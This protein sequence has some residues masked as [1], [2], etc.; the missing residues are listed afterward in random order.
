M[1]RRKY[2]TGIRPWKGSW[3]AYLEVNGKPI[4]QSFP[5]DTPFEEMR[6]WRRTEKKKYKELGPTRGSFAADIESYLSRIVALQSH[7][8]FK[9]ILELWAAA[10]GRNRPRRSITAADIDQTMQQWELEG[11]GVTVLRKRR[12]VLMALWHR[13]DGKHAQNP[14][15]GTRAPQAPKPEARG[16]PYPTIARILAA[17]PEGPPKR[18]AAVIAYTGLPPSIL[19][20]VTPADLDLKAGTVRVK[21]RRK[22]KGVEARTLPLI[23]DGIRA[24]RAFHAA[25]AYGYLAG[26][27]ANR[28]FQ[29]ACKAVGI[30]GVSLYDLRH[31]FGA[32][33]YLTT[34]DL[35]TVARFLLHS[36]T[37]L[38][39]RYAKAAN[40]EVDRRAAAELGRNLSVRT[41]TPAT[42]RKARKKLRRAS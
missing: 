36:S 5:L 21:P 42:A 8:Q 17:M 2:P 18:S 1:K 35:E 22:G 19:K 15:R 6:E 40:V 39:A 37:T 33:L 32:A 28:V 7:R 41:K 13:L 27:N 29:R 34:R 9:A 3:Q 25:D 26:R 24:F 30:R 10:L 11:V 12:T 38:T 23:P 14:V 4:A 31:S 16:L 20:Q